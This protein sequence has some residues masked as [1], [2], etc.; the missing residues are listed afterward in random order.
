M[1]K[2]EIKNTILIHANFIVQKS[3]GKPQ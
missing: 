3:H 1:G 2:K